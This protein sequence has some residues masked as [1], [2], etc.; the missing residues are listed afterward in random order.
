MKIREATYYRLFSFVPLVVSAMAWLF[1]WARFHVSSEMINTV[2]TVI[3]MSGIIGGIPYLA[4]AVAMFFWL[5]RKP[6]ST[7]PRHM[8]YLLLVFVVALAAFVGGGALLIGRGI[9]EAIGIAVVFGGWGLAIGS[10][11]LGLALFG[12]EF[13]R[14]FGIVEGSAP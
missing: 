5:G 8:V 3:A 1:I 11:Y 7:Y 13:L 14:R 2:L 6:D 4:V 10:A 12:C 9:R